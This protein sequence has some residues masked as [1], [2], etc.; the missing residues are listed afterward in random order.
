METVFHEVTCYSI[1]E[2][3]E[4]IGTDSDECEVNPRFVLE[5]VGKR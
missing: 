3:V 4:E 1:A 5:E 2:A